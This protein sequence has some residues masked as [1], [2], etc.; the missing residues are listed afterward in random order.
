MCAYRSA[1]DLAA[2]A[3]ARGYERIGGYT[4]P[5]EKRLDPMWPEPARLP[6]GFR[7]TTQAVFGHS[8]G[9]VEADEIVRQCPSFVQDLGVT[10]LDENDAVVSFAEAWLDSE[11]NVAEFE[12]VGTIPSHQKLGLGSA[13]VREVLGYRRAGQQQGWQA[14]G[15]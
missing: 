4:I 2:A 3:A 7:L 13:V 9:T 15:R 14:P 6:P 5:R 12:P 10:V 1:A 11:T 8:G